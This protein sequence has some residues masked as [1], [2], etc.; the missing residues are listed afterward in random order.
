MTNEIHDIISFY[1]H[2]IIIKVEQS[3]DFGLTNATCLWQLFIYCLAQ[4]SCETCTDE[5]TFL[6]I[7]LYNSTEKY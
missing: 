7:I 4:I 1:F 5:T 3:A 6:S 2:K